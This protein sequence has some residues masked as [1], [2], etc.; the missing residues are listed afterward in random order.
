M[1]TNLLSNAIKYRG[2]QP[3]VISVA[4]ERVASG[5]RFSVADNGIGI[6][7]GHEHE[8]FDLLTR[9]H[10]RAEIPGSGMGLAICE[11]ILAK[12]GGSIGVE[13]TLGLGSTFSFTLPEPEH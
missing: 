9:L 1:F 8:V 7:P 12:A 13:S 4:S 11:Q 3:P 2:A 10:T 5:W 6:E